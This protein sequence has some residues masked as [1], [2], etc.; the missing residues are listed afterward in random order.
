VAHT[1]YAAVGL[2]SAASLASSRF[3]TDE[4]RGMF[5]GLAAHAI[6]PLDRSLT[7]GVALMFA[8][9][10]HAV[11]WPVVRGGSQGIAI[12]IVAELESLGAEIVTGRR[13]SSIGELGA[14]DAV[15][16]DLTPAQV[17][18]VAGDRLPKRYRKAL[19][20]YRYGPG[21]CKVDYAL[22]E[23]VPW[24]NPEVRRAAT[25]HVGGTLPE[26][27][28]AEAAPHDGEHA[29]RPFVLFVQPTLADPSRAPE[30]R[31]VGWAYCHVPS[32]SDVDCTPAIDDQIERFA[33]GFRDVV[34]ARHVLTAADVERRDPNRVGGDIAGGVTDFRQ[35]LARPVLSTTPWATPAKGLYLCSAATPPGGGVHGM[36]GWHA[37]HAVLHD[38]KH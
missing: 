20:R 21:V 8:L 34:L 9:L 32:G 27:M 33:P 15:V 28:A 35:L 17:L 38:F 13:V 2:R 26:I 19:R 31:H 1:Q 10:A 18:A 6:L 5:A 3:D 16:L 11:G 14:A 29:A 37:A 30:G 12:S 24:T 25:V 4:A 36:C 7:G 22:S 23:P